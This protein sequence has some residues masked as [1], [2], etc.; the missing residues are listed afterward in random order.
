MSRRWQ[1]APC[2]LRRRSS[3]FDPQTRQQVQ[4]LLAANNN[5]AV[6]QRRNLHYLRGSVYCGGCGSRLMVI[7][8]QNRWG[9]AYTYLTCSG[10]KRRTTP[11]QRQAM[12]AELIEELVEDEYRTIALSPELRDTVENQILEEFDALRAAS[13]SERSELNQQRVELTAQRQKLLDAHYA[14]AIP[15]DLLKTEQE[16]IANR[17]GTFKCSSPLRPRTRRGPRTA[18]RHPRPSPRLPRRLP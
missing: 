11:C 2:P 7:H 10:R 8:A 15:L 1:S 6:Y 12:P 14:G 9:T 17:L 5:A 13:E 16:R 3:L 18:R 4:D